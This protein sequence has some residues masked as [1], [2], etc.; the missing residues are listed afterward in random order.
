M[1]DGLERFMNFISLQFII[2]LMAVFGV[3][4]I[5][6]KRFQWVCL[7]VAS[8]TFYL[9]SGIGVAAFLVFTT[10]STFYIGRLL[11]KVNNRSRTAL[12]EGKGTLTKD[13]RNRLKDD[14][15][16]KKRWILAVA[17]VVN[18]GILAFLKY[19]NFFAGN[20]NTMLGW[21]SVDAQLLRLNLLM[22][23]G[24]SFY[25]FQAA[26]YLF[27][28]Y[29]G[30]CTADAHLAKFALFVSFFPQIVQGPISRYD[31]LARQLYAP[32]KF[33][34]TQAKYGVCLMMWGMFKKLVI[35]DR[36]ALLVN[37][38]FGNHQNYAGIELFIAST[39]YCIQIYADFSG[40]ID[41]AI[42]AAQV[43]GIQ[44]S[45][46]FRRPYFAR[47]ITEFWQR[48][49]ITLGA[50]VR[51]YLFYPLCLSKPFTRL[52]KS[53]RRVFGNYVGK[54]LSTCL[55]TLIAFLVIGIWH[56]SSWKYVAYGLYNGGLITLALLLTP[57][58]DRAKKHIRTETFSWRLFQTLRTLVLVCIGR[59]FSRADSLMTALNMIKNTFTTHNPWILF[60]GSIYQLG[61]EAGD[62][63]ILFAGVILWL[64]ISV[65]QERGVGI[66]EWLNRQNIIFRW[67][68][69]LAGIFAVV[70]LSAGQD[71]VRGFIYAQF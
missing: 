49:H 46:N 22:P 66:R 45:P 58:F 4:Y 15:K 33:D 44:L 16:K 3:Y 36:A 42:G 50:W 1:W 31:Q 28:V 51:N 14:A 6:P 30:K 2:F 18:F 67:T 65:M 56:G 38:V 26:G 52:G 13:E 55:V 43:M 32:H 35:A 48:W 12:A 29:Q 39:F 64:F 9:F 62:M 23:L 68:A 8:Y 21:L 17:L 70:M 57:L 60:D 7:L 63:H 20:L 59:Y 61:L 11:D 24:I 27:D 34:Y 10:V 69:Y 54:I 41:I 5:V 47:S 53:A 19:Y 25:T 37:Q 71:L 40:G